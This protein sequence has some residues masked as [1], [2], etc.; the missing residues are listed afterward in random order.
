MKFSRNNLFL[1]NFV[2]LY[3]KKN[4]QQEKKVKAFIKKKF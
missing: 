4:K 3:F 2:K 1:L